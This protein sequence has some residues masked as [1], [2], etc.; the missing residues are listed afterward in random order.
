MKN[1][2]G[3]KEKFFILFEKEEDYLQVIKCIIVF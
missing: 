3:K 1:N 2:E